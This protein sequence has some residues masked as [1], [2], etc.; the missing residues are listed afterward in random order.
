MKR[1]LLVVLAVL[2]AACSKKAE[3]PKKEAVL[4][5]LQKEADQLKTDAEKMSPE[6]AVKSTWTIESI[7]VREQPKD[8]T[9]PWAGTVRFK[10]VTATKDFDGSEQFDQSEKRF[11]YVW[12]TALGK[13]L[14]KY[15]PTTPATPK[16]D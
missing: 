2:A 15:V 9:N 12:S 16:A 11:E 4:P 14:I 5:L 10:I 8:E 13:W 1:S 7:D 6:L 3:A